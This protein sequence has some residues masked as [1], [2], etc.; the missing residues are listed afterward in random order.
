MNYEVDYLRK[1]LKEYNI[2]PSNIRLQ[3]LDRL[4]SVKDHPTA[5]KLYEDL[6][7]SVPTLSKTSIYN[8]LDLFIEKEMVRP[9]ILGE[10]ETRFDIANREHGHFKCMVCKEVF[11]FDLGDREYIG[12]DDFNIVNEDVQ[13]FGICADCK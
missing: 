10:N 7:N 4:L 9:L 5:F 1:Y 12:I 6:L 8:T 11:D 13:L 3:L 2:N